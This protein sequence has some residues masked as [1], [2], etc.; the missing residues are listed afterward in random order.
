MTVKNARNFRGTIT[1]TQLGAV[2]LDL[3]APQSAHG[4]AQVHGIGAAQVIL[5]QYALFDVGSRL[6]QMPPID[7]GKQAAL[8]WRREPAAVF[9]HEHIANGAFRQLAAKVEK[10]HIV[11]AVT[12]SLL[13]RICI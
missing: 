7:A 5:V 6:Q 10:Q 8:D 2:P 1:A 9:L 13:K 4:V 12:N 11:E 3:D